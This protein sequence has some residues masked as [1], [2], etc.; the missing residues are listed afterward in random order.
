MNVKHFPLLTS[1]L[2]V[3]SWLAFGSGCCWEEPVDINA[4]GAQLATTVPTAPPRLP[5]PPEVMVMDCDT[6]VGDQVWAIATYSGLSAQE[7]YGLRAYGQA[8]TQLPNVPSGYF[9]FGVEVAL[10]DGS[11]AASCGG[12][13]IPRYTAM[14]FVFPSATEP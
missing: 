7:L 8:Y 10:K 14:V 1:F 13:T 9:Y 6:V 11:A 3:L 12:V 2:M 4:S 5:E